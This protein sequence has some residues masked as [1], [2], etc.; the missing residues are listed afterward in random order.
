QDTLDGLSAGHLDGIDIF[1]PADFAQRARTAL[2]E[3]GVAT[4]VDEGRVTEV[5]AAHAEK[6][7]AGDAA[8]R[9]ALAGEL[10]AELRDLRHEILVRLVRR[11]PAGVDLVRALMREGASGA[12]ETPLVNDVA[13]LANQGIL[14]DN[15]T[16]LVVDELAK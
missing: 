9:A 5:L 10:A 11:G 15:G 3:Q 7:L 13:A 16:L 2:R 1:V 14:G 12:D 4:G 6:A 8:A